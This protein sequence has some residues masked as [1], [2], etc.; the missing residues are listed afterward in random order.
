MQ[1]KGS[2]GFVVLIVEDE[3]LI[4]MNATDMVE[5]AGFEAITAVNADEAICALQSRDDI[6]VVFTDIDMPG[7]MDGLKLMRAVRRR[8]PPV[9]F[10][11]ASGHMK[12]NQS[13]VPAGG[14][15]FIK[16]YRASQIVGALGEIFARDFA[17]D[18]AA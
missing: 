10:I 1:R 2:K 12:V 16:P 8:W 17:F 5:D 11:A 3:P 15:F 7:S 14:F 9:Q 4:M 6:R 18:P 13:E